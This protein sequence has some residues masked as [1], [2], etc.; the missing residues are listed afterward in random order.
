MLFEVRTGRVRD[1]VRFDGGLTLYVDAESGVLV[2]GIADA[3]NAIHRITEISTEKEARAAALNFAAA[4]FGRKQAESL[5]EFYHDD[6]ACVLNV[7]GQ[8]FTQR[9]GKMIT[10][11]QKKQK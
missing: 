8:Y 11:A 5:M 9:L 10:K 1:N 7:C 6:A 2:R 4:I 3:Q